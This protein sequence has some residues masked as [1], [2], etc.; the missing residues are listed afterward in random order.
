M[1]VTIGIN[2]FPAIRGTAYNLLNAVTEYTDHYRTARITDAR[3]GYS[4]EQARAENAV[5]GTG[6]RLKS[7]ALAVIEELTA[8]DPVIESRVFG[9]NPVPSDD[10]LSRLYNL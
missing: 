7:S 4:I 8:D 10:D 2:A 1:K 6:E 9:S 5:I 3:Q